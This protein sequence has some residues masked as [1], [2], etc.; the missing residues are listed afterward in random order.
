MARMVNGSLRRSAPVKDGRLP[1]NPAAGVNLPR[2]TKAE[3]RY[4]RVEQV[5][6]LADAAGPGRLAVLVLAYTGIRWG[7]LAALRVSRVDLMRR[8]IHIVASVTEVDGGR[9][10]WGLP[11]S[12]ERRWV[13]SPRFLVDDLAALLAGRAADNLAFTTPSGAV[14]RVGGARRS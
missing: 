12:H 4:L 6:D 5:H 11:K 1:R 13:P 2:A 10:D 3:K 14:L 9:L 7:E 8:R